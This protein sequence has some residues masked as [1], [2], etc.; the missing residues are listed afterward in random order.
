MIGHAGTGKSCLGTRLPYPLPALCCPVQAKA[1]KLA[2]QDFTGGTFTVS[3]LGMYGVRQ[4]AAI[5]NPPQAAILAVGAAM[6]VVV[7][8]AGGVFGE[9]SVMAATLSCDH[10]VIDGAMGAEWLAAF[11]AHLEQPLL[12]LV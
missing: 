9:V 4:F 6:P 7:C 3:N 11:K 10:R 8:G 12:L 5:I 1:G 2:P